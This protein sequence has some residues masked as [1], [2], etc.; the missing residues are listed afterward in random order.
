M[1]CIGV[2]MEAHNADL[3]LDE[4]RTIARTETASVLNSSREDGYVEQGVADDDLFYWTGAE[5]G[6]SRQTEAC[7]WLIEKTNPFH[8]GN[9]VSLERLRE[10]VAEAPTHDPDMQDDL[11]R[12][13]NWV[14]HPNERSTFA[15]A[16][17]E[18]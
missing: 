6:D 1:W 4:A 13:E 8:G 12:P 2:S 16:P 3:T 9:P 18:T 10:L 15:K 5:P 14:I 7:E 17:P 11:A